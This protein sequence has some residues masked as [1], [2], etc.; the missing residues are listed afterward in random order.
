MRKKGTMITAVLKVKFVTRNTSHFKKIDP[1]FTEADAV[2]DEE[3]EDDDVQEPPGSDNPIGNI[4]IGNRGALGAG[5]PLV[6]QLTRN[7][8]E[9]LQH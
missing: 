1:S 4:N 6:F 8:S 9:I 2:S 5:A 7:S 3:E